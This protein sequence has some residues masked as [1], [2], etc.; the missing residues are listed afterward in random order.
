MASA[1]QCTASA[2]DGV[3]HGAGSAWA[4]A[5]HAAWGVRSSQV[6]GARSGLAAHRQQLALAHWHNAAGD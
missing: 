4:L 5:G 6:S 3:H 2:G 1:C